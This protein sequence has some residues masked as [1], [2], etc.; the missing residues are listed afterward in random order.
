MFPTIRVSLQNDNVKM[1]IT[2]TKLIQFCFW[3]VNLI[4][5]LSKLTKFQGPSHYENTP[6]QI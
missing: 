3:K 4:H 5:N 2:L 1:D 6:I